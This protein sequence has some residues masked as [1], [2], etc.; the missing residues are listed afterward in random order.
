MKTFEFRIVADGQM[1]R[2]MKCQE[3]GAPIMRVLYLRLVPYLRIGPPSLKIP[4]GL[5]T[6]GSK[7]IEIEF[8]A[9][10]WHESRSTCATRRP[11]LPSTSPV[12]IV[13][14]TLSGRQS[15]S[16]TPVK[17]PGYR[18]GPDSSSSVTNTSSSI[19]KLVNSPRM[20]GEQSWRQLPTFSTRRSLERH[21]KVSTT[22]EDRGPSRL[23]LR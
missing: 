15:T 6:R 18:G 17:T 20:S 9:A 3:G 22:R 12:G 4:P 13:I 10:N 11:L 19:S 7:V 14:A 1:Y 5:A 21:I 2:Q 16:D 8:P 23:R